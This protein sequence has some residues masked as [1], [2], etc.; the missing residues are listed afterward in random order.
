MLHH[1]NY[2]VR[3]NFILHIIMRMIIE[4]C[5]LSLINESLKSTREANYK[6]RN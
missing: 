5:R 4:L 3:N 2:S 6:L 1:Y